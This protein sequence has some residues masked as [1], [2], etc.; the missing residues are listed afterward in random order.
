MPTPIDNNELVLLIR[1]YLS[2]EASAQEIAFVER[3]YAFFELLPPIDDVNEK[4]LDALSVEMKTG[5]DEKI[6][7]AEQPTV[8]PFYRKKGWRLIAAAIISL[9]LVIGMLLYTKPT[10]FDRQENLAQTNEPA[11]SDIMPGSNKAT[12]ILG[13]G[14]VIT[15]DSAKTGRLADQDAATILK[16]ADGQ[17]AYDA[18]ENPL[19]P[20]QY[21]ML[22]TP[23]GGQYAVTL[24]DGSKALLN[25]QSTIRFPTVFNGRERK[26]EITGEVYFEVAKDPNKPF[27]AS[28]AGMAVEALGTQFNVNAYQEESTMATT[29]LEGKV[30]VTYGKAAHTIEPGQ[31]VLV[32]DRTG[33]TSLYTAV[34]VAA[35]MAW[36]NGL[37]VFKSQDIE[38]IMRQL[39]RWYDV[40][41]VYEGNIP[42]QTFT[43]TISRDAKLSAVLNMLEYAGIHFKID[44]RKIIVSP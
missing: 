31:Q 19:A 22:S 14:A 41:I 16:V 15:L 33:A 17:L 12:L 26:V 25:A 1:K 28:V 21:N 40:D 11:K 27:I 43:G 38:S 32:Q 23:R 42:D 29:L 20:A 36:K 30:R 10:L 24:P 34:D 4:P 6:R 3:Y 44:N 18:I 9:L 39:S 7:L 2:G 37:T 8:I 13:N 35:V 5:I